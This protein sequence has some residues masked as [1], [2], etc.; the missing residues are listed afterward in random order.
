MVTK[1]AGTDV[2]VLMALNTAAF[3]TASPIGNIQSITWKIDQ[4]ITQEP[5]GLGSRATVGKESVQKITGTIKRD[6]D[7]S[8][9]DPTTGYTFAQ[10]AN[11]FETLAL[12][13]KYIRVIVNAT[14][15]TT[16]L[17]NVIGTYTHNT[18]SVDGI[19]QEQYDFYADALYST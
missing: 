19:V 6:F 12:T 5:S 14:G 11:E 4:G 3:G 18:P 1:Y 9:V 7:A 13:R 8:V 15:E 17:M 2:Q 10:E 16:T